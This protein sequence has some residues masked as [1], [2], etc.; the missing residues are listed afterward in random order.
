MRVMLAKNDKMSP[1]RTGCLKMNSLTATVATRPCATRAGS[2]EPAKSTWAMTQPPKMSPLLLVS[3]GMG[4]TRSTSSL[5]LGKWESGGRL[6]R[7]VMVFY[8]GVSFSTETVQKC[9]QWQKQN[10]KGGYSSVGE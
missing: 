9:T 10:L 7:S 3:L 6:S 5:S 4:I 2:T 8:V 1:T